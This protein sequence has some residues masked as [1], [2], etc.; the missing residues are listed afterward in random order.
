MKK[1][2]FI[3]IMLAVALNIGVLRADEARYSLNVANFNSITVVDGI[4]VDYYCN[5]DSA[6]WIVFTA[7]PELASKISFSNNKEHLRIQTLADEK[8]F[9]NLP[10]VR[11]YS[12]ALR[13][14]ENSGDSTLRVFTDVPVDKFS[15]KQIGNGFLE[16]HGVQTKKFEGN[17]AA[18]HGRISV[19]GKADKVKLSNVGTGDIEASGLQSAAVECFIIGPGIIH[20]TAHDQLKVMGAGSGRVINHAEA[21]KTVNRSIG[22]KTET[23]ST[24][25]E[26]QP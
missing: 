10:T 6:G 3:T 8:P 13:Y 7:D 23:P 17:A 18:G 2:I 22:I 12:A 11:A 26:E 16:V 9:E 14:A 4:N 15:A 20:V 1:H 21:V 24:S 5:P 19:D 25:G